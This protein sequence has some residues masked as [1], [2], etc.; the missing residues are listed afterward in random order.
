[1]ETAYANKANIREKLMEM[2]STYHPANIGAPQTASAQ[3][4]PE[5]QKA[6]G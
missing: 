1:M 2:V 5:E 4:A 6:V 3:P